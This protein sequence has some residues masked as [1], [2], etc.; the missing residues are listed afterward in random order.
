M[1]L[2]KRHIG[3][4]CL[5]TAAALAF[6]P[7]ADAGLAGF[8]Q[9]HPY[10]YEEELLKMDVPPLHID[11]YREKMRYNLIMLIDYIK[12]QKPDFQIIAHGDLPVIA[13]LLPGQNFQQGR[14]AGAIHTND[15]DLLSL[16]NGKIRLIENFP[17]SVCFCQLFCCQ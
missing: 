16:L 13:F 15:P 6:C 12:Q 9:A 1:L 11:N 10:T 3:A 7:K 8:T 5:Y 14:F 17:L 2:L 4:L